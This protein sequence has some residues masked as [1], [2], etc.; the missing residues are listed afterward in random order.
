MPEPTSVLPS[1][2]V[3]LPRRLEGFASLPLALDYAAKGETGF[4]FYDVRANRIASLPYAELRERAQAAA[5]GMVQAGWPAGSRFLLVADTTPDIITLFLA[6][7]YA[8]IVP[9]PVALPAGLGGK[10]AYVA[11]LRRQLEHSGAIA[12]AAPAE[13]VGFLNEAAEGLDLQA[14]APEAFLSLPR[15]AADLRPFGPHDLCYLQYSSGSTRFPKGIR[16]TQKAL[17]ANAT[18][19]ARDGLQVRPG[20]RCAS[21]LPLYHD[22]GLVGF[23]LVPLFSQLTVDF[24]PT[25][26]F[27]RRPRVWLQMIS[28]NRGTLAFSPSFG[29]DLCVRG[30]PAEV[31]AELD[32]S[33]WR[34]AG[35]GG[36]MIQAPILERFADTFGPRGFRAQAFVPSYGMAEATLALTFAPLD[37]G[38]EADVLVRSDLADRGVATAAA[39]RTPAEERVTFVRCGRILPGH[40]LEVRDE[41][42][43]ILPEGRVGRI[44]V[45]GPSVTDGY[46]D[47]PDVTAEVIQDGWLDTGDLGF[48]RDGAVTIT[49]RAKD[50]IIVN[51]RNVWPHDVEWSVEQ[52]PGLR[53]G[54]VAAFQ[55]DGA[56]GPGDIVLLIQCR[57]GDEDARSELE[58]GAKRLA[59]QTAAIDAQVVLVPPHGLPRTSSGKLSRVRAKAN[60]VGGVYASGAPDRAAAG[61]R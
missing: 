47:E 11:T 59:Q 17:A 48:L 56:D 54:D 58:R 18:G 34:A 1:D 9:V 36:D 16:V 3:R 13:L 19:I 5:R 55:L 39:E 27:A 61:K 41:T 35:I 22:M 8:S 12:A 50:L 25:R 40:E 20:D 60:F 53:R 28:R 57:L 21:W 37:R 51:G 2:N 49:G 33:S 10:E 44:F 26:E 43:A 32:L 7:Q 38:I 23:M 29:F 4:D 42:G 6:C 30:V 14:G 24:L 31:A 15:D 46:H 52:L 45:R